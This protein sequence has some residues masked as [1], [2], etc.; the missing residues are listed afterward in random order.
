M[1][2]L[3]LKD[4]LGV[5]GDLMLVKIKEDRAKKVAVEKRKL[6]LLYLDV[7]HFERKMKKRRCILEVNIERS[8]KKTYVKK[9]YWWK[10]KYEELFA[11]YERNSIN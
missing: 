1:C 2:P 8:K 11:S 6:D 3:I 10:N 9:E 7:N 4:I 5:D